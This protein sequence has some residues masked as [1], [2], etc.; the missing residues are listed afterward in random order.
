M[1]KWH[2]NDCLYIYI[3]QFILKGKNGFWHL[4]VVETNP[5][6]LK[7]EYRTKTCLVCW[8]FCPWWHSQS[9]LSEEDL[10]GA[11]VLTPNA[12]RW[13]VPAWRP[14]TSW[15]RH[16]MDAFSALQALCEG[17]SPVTG[18]F[19]SQRPVAQSFDVF[20]DLRLNTGLGKQRPRQLPSRPLWRHSNVLGRN[21]L[22]PEALHWALQLRFT[23]VS[24]ILSMYLTPSGRRSLECD[25]FEVN[26][27]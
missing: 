7:N 8:R 5:I 1:K 24:S 23:R 19:P 4:F 21:H 2:H 20:F 17:N 15:W 14:V 16:Q 27:K 10:L 9:V 3:S 12:V 22:G 13:E 11:P 26:T 18:E 6:N 25:M